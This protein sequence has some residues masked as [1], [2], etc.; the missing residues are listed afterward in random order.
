MGRISTEL[1]GGCF[2]C[3][4]TLL[5]RYCAVRE[6]IGSQSQQPLL[7][8][9]RGKKQCKDGCR[10][11]K[12]DRMTKMLNINR[13]FKQ[14]QKMFSYFSSNIFWAPVSSSQRMFDASVGVT[15][16]EG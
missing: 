7:L 1:I 6:S 15:H 14:K 9:R 5:K 13:P 10:E 11:E 2:I 16:E 4:Y 3:L 8:S 12:I